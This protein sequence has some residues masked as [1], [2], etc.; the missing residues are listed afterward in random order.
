MRGDVTRQRRL[1]PD[2]QQREAEPGGERTHHDEREGGAEREYAVLNRPGQN[3]QH[4]GAQRPGG[5]PAHADDRAHDRAHAGDAF[6]QSE[7]PGA[8]VDI[9]RDHRRQRVP[10]RVDAQHGA[11]EGDD[12]GPHPRARANLPP[13]RAQ[14]LE[15]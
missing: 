13:T 12:R 14:V 15:H 7:D 4:A 1:P 8:A 6:E 5:L 3:Q 2:H 10:L 11:G 9:T